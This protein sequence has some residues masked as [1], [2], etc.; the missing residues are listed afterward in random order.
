MHQDV[1][2]WEGLFIVSATR[3][4]IVK[5]IVLGQRKVKICFS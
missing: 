2:L 3:V 5:N 4:V 1:R